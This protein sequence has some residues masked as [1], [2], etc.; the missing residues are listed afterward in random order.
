MRHRHLGLLTRSTDAHAVPMT[1]AP[2]AAPGGG[3]LGEGL[4][5]SHEASADSTGY[6]GDAGSTAPHQG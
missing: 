6:V 2:H 1:S 3:A 4:R 5:R